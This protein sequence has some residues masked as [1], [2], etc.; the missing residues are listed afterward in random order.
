MIKSLSPST[1]RS[2]KDWQQVRKSS[3]MA[4]EP[5]NM[6]TPCRRGLSPDLQD[7]NPVRWAHGKTFITPFFR[8]G[9]CIWMR[10]WHDNLWD[11]G[12]ST[13]LLTWCL[14]GGARDVKRPWGVTQKQKEGGKKKEEKTQK[15]GEGKRNGR[16]EA[17]K[18]K[19]ISHKYLSSSV[20]TELSFHNKR[21][22]GERWQ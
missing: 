5:L 2:T 4:I 15:R 12:K 22:M 13:T 19:E 14:W 1:K 9:R 21:D 3:N 10:W 17:G 7:W 20:L 11:A 18:R 16:R 6:I 8:L